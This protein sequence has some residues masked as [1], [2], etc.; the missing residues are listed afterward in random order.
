MSFAADIAKWAEKTKRK[1][2]EINREV[3]VNLS[4]TVINR[5]PIG[6][7]SIWETPPTEKRMET[8]RPGTLVNSWYSE[9]GSVSEGNE[10]RS[11]STS[12]VTSFAQLSFMADEA[13]GEVFYFTNPAPYARR[14]EFGWSSQAPAGMVRV[15]VAEFQNIVRAAVNGA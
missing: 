4:T 6:D 3:V 15:T 8:Y 2:D 7:I 1:K 9:I 11:P 10:P 5:T 14:V 13:V 12:G